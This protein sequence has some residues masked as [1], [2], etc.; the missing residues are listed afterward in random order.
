MNRI[1][2]GVIPAAGEGTRMG[3]LSQVL[4]KCLFPVYDRPV[5]HS[6]VE[7]MKIIGVEQI[8][9]IVNYQKERLVEYFNSVV[10]EI[11]ISINFIEQK[12]LSGIAGAIMLT[13]HYINEPFMVILGDDCTIT[14][15]LQNL[16]DLFFKRSATV[17]EGIVREENHELLKSTC[18]VHLGESGRILEIVEKPKNPVSNLRGCGVYAFSNDIFSYIEKTP[19][20]AIRNEVEITQTID[21]V[22]RE[23]K[24]FGEFIDG[25]N[26]NINS[27][28]DLLRAWILTRELRTGLAHSSEE[29]LV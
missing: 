25:V 19:A 2:L 26:I 24:A 23:K 8:Y 17:V 6:I 7:N 29:V 22:A 16:V 1:R 4:P 27:Y 20:S 21:L 10:D 5:I 3:Y 12:Q 14:P 15:S 11:S 28:E 9:V 18:C 13:S